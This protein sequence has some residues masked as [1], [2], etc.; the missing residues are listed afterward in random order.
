MSKDHVQVVVVL[1]LP[2]VHFT[3]LE[4][5][6]HESFLPQKTSD[7]A[8]LDYFHRLLDWTGLFMFISLFFSLFFSV[9]FPFGSLC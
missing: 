2:F 3:Q 4:T 7:T 8:S 6:R 5:F 9:N 1:T